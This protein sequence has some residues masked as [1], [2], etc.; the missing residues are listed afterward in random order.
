MDRKIDAGE[1]AYFAER[2]RL[3]LQSAILSHA[4]KPK[5]IPEMS[6]AYIYGEKDAE[7][8]AM[9]L[10]ITKRKATN[11]LLRPYRWTLADVSNLLRA[12]DDSELQFTIK[13]GVKLR[14]NRMTPTAHGEGE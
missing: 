11:L 2:L 14:E 10:G 9:R 5:D 4:F 8:L 1:L 3:R 13:R 7:Y 6:N 12:Y